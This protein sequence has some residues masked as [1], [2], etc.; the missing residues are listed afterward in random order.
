MLLI[1]NILSFP[2]P[3]SS[4]SFWDDVNWL[5]VG[6]VFISSLLLFSYW[7]GKRIKRSRRKLEEETEQPMYSYPD[8]LMQTNNKS[9]GEA[10][11]TSNG[12]TSR[13]GKVLI[14][15]FIIWLLLTP[16]KEL[17]DAGGTWWF[18]GYRPFVHFY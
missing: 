5:W 9:V 1:L 14:W 8:I 7:M 4:Y 2:S 10:L 3:S 16:M 15:L 11:P 6:F 17:I 13:L 18:S 12:Y